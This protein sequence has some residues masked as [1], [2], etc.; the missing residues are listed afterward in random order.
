M[1]ILIV[2]EALAGAGGVETYLAAL[3]PALQRRGHQVALLHQNP[4]ATVGPTRLDVASGPRASVADE[5]L[6]V[7]AG[8]LLAWGPD[9][10]FSHNLPGLHIDEWLVARVPVVKMMHGY[11]GTCVGGHKAHALPQ[12][13]PC[14]RQFGRACLG[15]YLPRRCGQGRPL[16]MLRQFAWARR[17]NR[18]FSRYAAIVVA[19]EHM[20]D[21]Y[22]RHGAGAVTAAPLFSTEPLADEPRRPPAQATVLFAGR[23]TSLKGGGVLVRSASYANARLDHPVRLLFAG[24]GPEQERWRDRAAALGVDAMFA[25]WVTGGARTALFRNAS[26]VAV[27]SLWPE[28]FGLVGLEAAAHGV[29]AIA[30]DVGGVREW[31]RDGVSGRLVADV[32]SYERFGRAIVDL[33]TT[34]GELDRL[35]AGARQVA[36]ELSVDVHLDILERV[37]ETAAGAEKS[38]AAPGFR[39]GG[40]QP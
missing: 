17:Q 28:P 7:A 10:C 23:M 31:L 13:R 22:R 36:V 2:H 3:M 1:R 21:E 40:R 19:S 11:F 16:V 6:D 20:A 15:V 27:P 24:D 38:H 30:F 4:E 26:L 37:F 34:P 32:G 12:V 25:G 14:A 18:L 9:V 33:V 5:G 39:A 8:R 29:P 35:A